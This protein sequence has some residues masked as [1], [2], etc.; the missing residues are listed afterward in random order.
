ML[1]I[2]LQEKSKKHSQ[3]DH[4]QVFPYTY[5]LTYLHIVV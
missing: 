1:V 5:A 3:P 4:L 2:D